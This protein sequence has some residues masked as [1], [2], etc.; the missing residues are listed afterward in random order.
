MGRS[1]ARI[2]T[3]REQALAA[4]RARALITETWRHRHESPAARALWLRAIASFRTAVE[5][6]YPPGFWELLEKLPSGD[7]GAIESAVLFLEA[8][9]W[10]FRSGYVKVAV[11]RKLK[12]LGLSPEVQEKIRAVLVQVVK[13]RDRREF[14]AYCQLARS[15]D[16]AA[17]REELVPLADSSEAQVRR[18]ARWMLAAL[19]R[20]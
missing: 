18:H 20:S 11:I 15:V 12:R 17:L 9:P 7:P 14:R 16:S 13:G 5:L 3:V 8:D 4:E 10:F 2:A 1:K 6:A 19:T